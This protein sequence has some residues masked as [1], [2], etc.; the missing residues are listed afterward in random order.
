VISDVI[1]RGVAVDPGVLFEAAQ[2]AYY[3]ERFGEA[4][5]G[6]KRILSVLETGDDATRTRLGPE[7]LWHIGR[8]FQKT[9]RMIEA[10]VA[11]RTGL[12]PRW[13]GDPKYDS[14]NAKQ[15]HKSITLVRNRAPDDPLLESKFREAQDLV[16]KYQQGTGAGDIV[17]SQAKL[18]YDQDDYADARARFLQVPGD[19]EN[20]EKARVYAAVCL[21]KLG[22]PDQAFDDLADYLENYVTDPVHTPS[23]ESDQARRQEAMGL[24]RYY[25]GLILYTRA[26]EGGG[27]Y[28]PVIEWLDSYWKDFPAQDS[29]GPKTIYMTLKAFL[30]Q[31]DVE[32]AEARLARLEK[33]YPTSAWTG[34][35]AL[36]IYQVYSDRRGAAAEDADTTALTRGMAENLSL[37]NRLGGS[38]K[39]GTMRNESLLWLELREWAKAEE[40]L[41]RA[42]KAF[43]DDPDPKVQDDL[44]RFFLP[45]LA[46]A[47]LKQKKVREAADLLVRLMD[48]TAT[49][50]R[51]TARDFA[52]AMTGWVEG[53]G[54]EVVEVPGIGGAENLEKAAGILV[55]LANSEDKWTASWYELKFDVAYAY[56][57]WGQVDGKK[58]VSAKEQIEQL[59]TDLSDDLAGIREACGGDDTL[60]QRFLWL[61]SKL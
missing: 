16:L 53:E 6:F 29:F 3:E 20:Y 40:I 58:L 61:L 24:A 30:A 1:D 51:Q 22:D 25:G 18:A 47:Q 60:R 23:S 4:L 56:Y 26:E 15:Y 12:E 52:A 55:K 27:D 41:A 42:V 48:E 34:H 54:R 50:S 9:D 38:P 10:A 57:Q 45:D 14:E 43:G 31:G 2:G 46:H 7:V 36:A 33:Q 37:F 32:A 44:K 28:A 35:G 13:Q 5:E 19:A 21:N 8:S 17:F 11:F 59:Q 39:L 49:P